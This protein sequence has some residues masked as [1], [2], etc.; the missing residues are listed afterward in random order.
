MFLN[1]CHDDFSL[2][3]LVPHTNTSTRARALAEAKNTNGKDRCDED[4]KEMKRL[5]CRR[6]ERESREESCGALRRRRQRRR[7]AMGFLYYPCTVPVL[8]VPSSVPLFDAL[9]AHLLDPST[10]KTLLAPSIRLWFLLLLVY[11]SWS[12]IHPASSFVGEVGRVKAS[13]GTA[14]RGSDSEIES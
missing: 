11:E 4:V 1:V 8:L 7:E 13:P 14:G 6:A 10:S 3:A 5:Y 2:V 9:A 12:K